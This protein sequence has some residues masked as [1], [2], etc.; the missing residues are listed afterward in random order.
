M[1]AARSAAL[2]CMGVV[3]H[4][5]AGRDQSQETKKPFQV[6]DL[7]RLPIFLAEWT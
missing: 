1:A 3:A 6:N 7:Q 4:W 2:L 5:I